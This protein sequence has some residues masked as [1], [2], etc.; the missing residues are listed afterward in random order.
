MNQPL[1]DDKANPYK[2]MWHELLTQRISFLN[3]QGITAPSAM[4]LDVVLQDMARIELENLPIEMK[5]SDP[6][7]QRLNELDESVDDEVESHIF[8]MHC[9]C[10]PC[11]CED[12]EQ[13]LE[14]R[15]DAR[16]YP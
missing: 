4:Q 2:R 7:I 1:W 8:C 9:E 15:Q 12:M 6:A 13:Q 16:D 3:A 14:Q 5:F 11:Q 10:A